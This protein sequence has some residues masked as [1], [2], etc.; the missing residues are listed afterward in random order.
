MQLLYIV[1]PW[2]LFAP[3]CV[4]HQPSNPGRA[5]QAM[6]LDDKQEKNTLQR[7]LT[8]KPALCISPN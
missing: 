4:Q 2:A 5:R 6:P 1:E 8:T 3:V 7:I